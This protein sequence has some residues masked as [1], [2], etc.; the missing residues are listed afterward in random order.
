MPC[1]QKFPRTAL[2]RSPLVAAALLGLAGCRRDPCRRP[3]RLIPTVRLVRSPITREVADFEDFVGQTMAPMTIDVRARVTGYLEKVFFDDGS[4]VLEKEVLKPD[5]SVAKRPDGAPIKELPVLFQIDPRPYEAEVAR[6]KAA[7]AQAEAHNRRLEAD[8]RRAQALL[9]RDQLARADYDLTAGD[10]AESTAMVDSARAQFDLAQLN[11]GFTKVTA[12]IGGR[13]SRRLVDPGNLVTQDSTILTSIVSLDPIYVYFDLDERTLLRLRRLVNAGKIK[14]RTE[15][16]IPV[17]CGLSDEEGFPHR[18]LINFS[19]NRLDTSTGTLRAR[20]VVPNPKPRAFSP[21]MYMKVHLP[22]GVPHQAMLV[23]EEA[24][25]TDQG[26]KYVIVV[27]GEKTVRQRRLRAG[28][29]NFQRWRAVESGRGP[30]DKIIVSGIQRVRPGL[31]VTPPSRPRPTISPPRRACRAGPRPRPPP[32]RRRRSPRPPPPRRLPPRPTPDTAPPAGPSPRTSPPAGEPRPPLGRWGAMHRDPSRRADP[33]DPTLISRFFIDRPI[34]ASV[35]SIVITLAG[36]IAL[37]QL[38]IALYPPISPPVVQVDCNFPGAS[39]QVVSESVASPIEQQVNGV[40]N[41]LYMSSQCTNDGS[42]NLTV[43]FKHGVDL[44]MALVMVQNRVSLATPMLPDVLKQTGVNVKKKAPDILMAVAV[45]SPDNTRDQLFLSNYAL[46]NMKEVIARLP[47]VSDV[48]MLGQRDYSMRIW[49]DP[50][51]MAARN[52]QAGDIIA[53]IREQNQQI[54]TGQIGQQPA[55]QGQAIQVPLSTLG[56]LT[57]VAQFENIIIRATEDGRF[58]RV[59]DVARV[60]LG[61]LTQD[62]NCQVNGKPSVSM[63]IFQL[64]DANALDTAVIVKNKIAELAKDFPDGVGWEIRYDTTP[65]ITESIDEVFKTLREAVILV[66]IVVLLFLQSWRS[67]IIPLIAVPVA[68][69]G[70]FAAMA[71]LG[72]SLNNLTLFGA[73]SLAIGI[74]V[75]DAIVVVEAVEHHIEGGMA[76]RE[77]TIRAMEQVSGPVIAIGLVLTA[78]FVPCAF[79]SGIVGQFFR[80][81]ALTIATSTVISAFNSL[82]LL[83]AWPP[84]L[85][86]PGRRARATAGGACLRPGRPWWG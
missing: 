83:A 63:A 4:E 7:L 15:A 56:R 46:L 36:G 74:V 45:N 31:E 11:L 25:G 78:V 76:P 14:S 44:N 82:A 35:L 54:A 13:L 41:M 39:A 24:L 55:P 2:A 3:S 9:A 68:I 19:D 79:I 72:F 65:Y 70:T 33:G 26:E 57:D 66:A 18:G 34:F 1:P 59:R 52:L 48:S 23:P 21:G 73:G 81:F 38:P 67:S 77:A 43:T 8:Y 80:Q 60:E 62:L 16:E 30:D 28:T 20:A 17:F 71:A 6:T 22:V 37:T 85:L 86:G 5:G 49:V 84:C 40:E 75:D 50:D 53:A 58:L 42:Y 51:K 10:Y 61:A 69:V 32:P 64:P 47:G 27:D 12:P 29:L